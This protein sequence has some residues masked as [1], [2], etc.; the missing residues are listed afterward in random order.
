MSIKHG[1][2]SLALDRRSLQRIKCALF[3]SA[4][5]PALALAKTTAEAPKLPEGVT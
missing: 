1:Q 4:A 3:L 5:L 2:F